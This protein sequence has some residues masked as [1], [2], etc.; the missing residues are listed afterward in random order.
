MNNTIY[1]WCDIEGRNGLHHNQQVPISTLVPGLDKLS[2]LSTRYL[3][4]GPWDCVTV[5]QESIQALKIA[6]LV[7]P[8]V[9]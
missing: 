8:V 1:H 5:T 4:Q 3:F 9:K 7:I 6:T 2:V